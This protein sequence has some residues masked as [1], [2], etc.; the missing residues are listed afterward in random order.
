MSELLLIDFC[1]CRSALKTGRP[2]LGRPE[3]FFV[4]NP[5]VQRGACPYHSAVVITFAAQVTALRV[6]MLAVFG[7][8]L[9]K[10]GLPKVQVICLGVTEEIEDGLEWVG[11][12]PLK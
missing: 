7:K 8:G 5:V 9:V 12:Q 1:A 11:G 2:V 4:E 6:H 3:P 10:I